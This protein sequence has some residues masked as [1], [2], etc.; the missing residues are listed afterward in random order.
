MEFYSVRIEQHVFKPC[1]LFNSLGH[2]HFIFRIWSLPVLPVPPLP[3]TSSNGEERQE[4]MERARKTVS[5]QI[6]NVHSLLGIPS[7]QTWK[8]IAWLYHLEAEDVSW[9][10]LLA[11]Q[12]NSLKK[13]SEE[14]CIATPEDLPEWWCE[15]WRG[16]G[17]TTPGGKGVYR[18][19]D[20][21][22]Y[23]TSWSAINQRWHYA[24]TQMGESWGMGPHIQFK[25]ACWQWIISRPGHWI[26]S[27]SDV[28]ITLN[29]CVSAI[30]VTQSHT[31]PHHPA[32]AIQL[33]DCPPRRGSSQEP[34]DDSTDT[35]LKRLDVTS[36][37]CA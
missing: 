21:C 16:Q 33:P 5:H 11:W 35:N 28:R 25:S 31:I 10:N 34:S 13:P 36:Q 9:K 7:R 20:V 17:L 15:A 24:E 32:E 22:H 30:L 26:C 1:I 19:K 8:N 14:I 3:H 12:S 6:R 27:V 4:D 2:N 29:H 18:V 37:P 23:P